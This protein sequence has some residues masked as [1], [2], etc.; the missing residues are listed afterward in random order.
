MAQHEVYV[1]FSIHGTHTFITANKKIELPFP[2][3]MG[4]ELEVDGL[5]FKVGASRTSS[6]R[7][8]TKLLAKD[9][10]VRGHPSADPVGIYNFFSKLGSLGWKVVDADFKKKHAA[11]L[12]SVAPAAPEPELVEST[13]P[14]PTSEPAV[15]EQPVAPDNEPDAEPKSEPGPDDAGS[16]AEIDP[17]KSND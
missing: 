14:A 1:A 7:G 10:T 5:K 13:D 16:E 3:A 9:L 4:V 11:K 17:V 2:P 15:E 6:S 12:T 8:A